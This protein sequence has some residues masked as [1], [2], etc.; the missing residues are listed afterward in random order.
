M[1]RRNFIAG[2]GLAA[3]GASAVHAQTTARIV[4]GY[5]AGGAVDQLARMFAEEFSKSMGRPYIVDMQTGASGQ[6][7]ANAVKS[8][9]QDGNTLLLAPASGMTIYPHSVRKPSAEPKDFVPVAIA[10]AHEIGLA[11][12]LDPQV[13]DFNGFRARAKANPITASYATPG[14][15]TIG[16]LY[17]LLLAQ[18]TGLPLN[19]VAYRG[20]GPAINDVIGGHIGAAILT[21][22]ALVPHAKAGTLRVVATT[23][24]KRNPQ[25]PDVPTFRELG[26]PQIDGSTWFGLFA[27]AG[28]PAPVVAR[29]ND[30]VVK[31]LQ[32]PA[33]RE[34]LAKLDLEPRE[35]TPAE[36]ANVIRAEYEHW[37]KVVKT[38]GLVMDAQ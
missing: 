28:T 35:V 22:G 6:I 12:R 18:A 26:L 23:G 33:T 20:V 4:T 2:I 9:P 25:L 17:G 13:P 14:P 11:V 29:L 1:K 15:G 36:F 10:A 7:A 5:A 16:H 37:G 38:S 8:A 31:A 24:S 30:I 19:H 32:R 3:T 34:T 27:P 21:L